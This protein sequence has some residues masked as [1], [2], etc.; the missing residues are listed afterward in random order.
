MSAPAFS[1]KVPGTPPETFS[2]WWNYALHPASSLF[3]SP[4]L[5]K[6]QASFLLSFQKSSS[7]YFLSDSYLVSFFHFIQILSPSPNLL[8]LIIQTYVNKFDKVVCL[9]SHSNCIFLMILTI[10][11]ATVKNT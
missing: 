1:I 10:F 9:D 6:K 11:I 3:K 2:A 7:T 5:T 8:S 4:F